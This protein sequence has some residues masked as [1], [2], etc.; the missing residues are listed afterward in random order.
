MVKNLEE[1]QNACLH[2]WSASPRHPRTCRLS[3][4]KTGSQK[5][6]LNKQWTNST[7]SISDSDVQ[8]S[9]SLGEF[10]DTQWRYLMPELH[11]KLPNRFS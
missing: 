3:G 10:E 2:L 8:A 5:N 1:E 11:R 7:A 4:S 9:F 6:Y